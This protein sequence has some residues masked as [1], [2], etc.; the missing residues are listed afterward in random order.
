MSTQIE[1][2]QNAELPPML[3]EL[4]DESNSVINLTG[5][6][7]TLKIGDGTTNVLTKTTGIT[8]SSSGVTVNWAAGDLNVAAG[9]YTAEITASQ[10]NLDYRRQFTFIVRSSL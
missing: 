1:Y 6:T 8:C 9:N 3:V 7:G 10:A 2:V 4:V 5:F